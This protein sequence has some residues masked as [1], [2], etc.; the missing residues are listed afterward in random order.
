MVAPQELALTGKL[1]ADVKKQKDYDP[2]PLSRELIEIVEI[3]KT[4]TGL[5]YDEI[6]NRLVTSSCAIRH[7]MA[8]L[9]RRFGI[10][11]RQG[12]NYYQRRERLIATIEKRGYCL[13]QKPEKS[14]LTPRKI[15]VLT[16]VREKNQNKLIA[17]VLKISPSTVKNHMT[18][19]MASLGARSR[20]GAIIEAKRR[21]LLSFETR[22]KIK[23][24]LSR[25]NSLSLR[26]KE[27]L[28]ELATG[29]TN[30]EIAQRLRIKGQTVRNHND[31]IYKKLEIHNRTQAM[32]FYQQLVNRGVVIFSQIPQRIKI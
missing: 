32:L 27:V 18:D 25:Y 2:I 30:K 15:E 11:K 4:D 23:F 9:Y 16:L 24:L 22:G 20:T 14:L 12:E 8:V 29:A 19:I 3:L 21:G 10:A 28:A 7:R 31:Y 13:E 6:G 1:S 5:P 26:E 17:Q